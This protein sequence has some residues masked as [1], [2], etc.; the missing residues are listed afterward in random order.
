MTDAPFA[1]GEVFASK[2]DFIPYLEQNI[3]QF[4]RI[5]IC[6]IGG[7]A[8]TTILFSLAILGKAIAGPCKSSPSR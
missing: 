3:T 8:D 5:D 2:W 1:I 6:N 4:A 7:I